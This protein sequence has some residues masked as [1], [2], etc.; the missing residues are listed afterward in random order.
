MLF[1]VRFVIVLITGVA[2]NFDWGGGQKNEKFCDV[3]LVT[4]F[5]NIMAMTSL[6]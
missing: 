5:G 4:F 2:K 3:F 1:A 6:K